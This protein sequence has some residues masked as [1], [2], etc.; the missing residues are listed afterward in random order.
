MSLNITVTTFPLT[1]LLPP[2][3]MTLSSGLYSCGGGRRGAARILSDSF[4]VDFLKFEVVWL[5]NGENRFDDVG[6]G[7]WQ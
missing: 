7:V 4:C 1:F 6:V 5:R 3:A 2:L